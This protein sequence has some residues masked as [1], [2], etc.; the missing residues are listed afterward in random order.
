MEVIS[1]TRE[2]LQRHIATTDKQIDLRV[3]RFNE[4]GGESLLPAAEGCGP[5]QATRAEYG[6]GGYLSSRF[7][8]A[9]ASIQQSWMT[10]Q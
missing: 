1:S 4:R 3:V 2:Q 9:H 10:H 8:I 7:G 5:L 6:I